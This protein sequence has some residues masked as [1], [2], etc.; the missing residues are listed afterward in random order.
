MGWVRLR[1]KF[2][3]SMLLTSAALTAVSLLIVQRTVEN[4]VRRN[5]ANDL[6]NSVATFRN[7][8]RER[9][10]TLAR[11][12]ELIA[13]LP[14]LKALMTSRHA[15]TIQD[16][17]TDMFRLSGGDLFALIDT[18]DQVV[19][20]HTG[21]PGINEE[22]AQRLF[23]SR[24]SAYDSLQ[25]WFAGGH[26]YEVFLEPIYN[27]PRER[28]SIL[29]TVA[30]GYEINQQVAQQ[31]SRIAASEVAVICQDIVVVSTLNPAQA[32]EFGG[33][34]RLHT[35][36]K[37]STDLKLGDENFVVS[38]IVLNP[39]ESPK[40]TMVVMKSYDQAAAFLNQLRQL[41][42]AVGLGAVFLGSVLVYVTARTFTRP[43]ERLVEGVR[44]LGRGDFKYP[45]QAQ[46]VGE[47][48]EL[49]NAF[50]RMRDDLHDT[51]QRLLASERLATIG[52]MASS[53]SHDLRHP[54]TAVLANAEFLA[55]ANLN[56]QQREE[57]YLEIRIAV[58]RLTDLVDSL[59]ELSRPAESLNPIEAVVERTSSRAI[60]LIRAHP[61][62][63]KVSVGIE[64]SGLHT[65][66]F[67]PR[68][69]ERVFYNLLLNACQ[70]VQSR[71]GHVAVN[72][73][74]M[75]DNL[76]IRI[77]DDGPGVDASIR[78]RLFQ[79]FVSHGKENGTGL[80]LTIAQKI[81]QDHDG[82]LQVEQSVPGYTVMRII[83]P[84][85]SAR[86]TVRVTAGVAE[87]S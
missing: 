68:K 16:A 73:T 7:V 69:M 38:S 45:L 72:V 13:D 81:V 33:D 43:L 58:N 24:R 63:Q 23:H 59:L 78:D 52:R 18:S 49:T 64:S 46:G 27:G 47:I 87:T 48:A 65:A 55:D 2:L 70:A 29:G 9:E 77:S 74:S 86:K 35:A 51:Q 20:F 22:Q 42:L 41:L 19:G 37:V 82:S 1:T 50:S 36:A 10:A 14:I 12:A 5:L 34:L 26:L 79:P 44:A 25:W 3:I 31:V 17:S 57:L 61:E 80:G 60:E 56:P 53:I 66:Q 85:V 40:V 30:I 62:F 4:Q 75:E 39:D 6:V 32:R 71:G 84:R 15:P 67:D 54:L 83:L 8:Q 76:E 28:N 21:S 11:S